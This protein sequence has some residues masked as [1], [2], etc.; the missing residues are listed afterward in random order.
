MSDVSREEFEALKE[1]VA[2]LEAQID[3]GDTTAAAADG[4][5]HRDETVLAHM[6]ENGRVSKVSLVKLYISLTDIQDRGKAKRRAR[7]LE[8]T[9]AYKN[10]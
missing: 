9:E 10:L 8:Q 4:L 2:E 7:T 3:T 6:R 5:D 1:R